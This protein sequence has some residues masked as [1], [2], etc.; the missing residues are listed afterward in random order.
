MMKSSHDDGINFSEH[1]DWYMC[2][3]MQSLAHY[4]WCMIPSASK[5]IFVCDQYVTILNSLAGDFF[6]FKFKFAKRNVKV[7]FLAKCHNFFAKQFFKKQIFKIW[8]NF[9]Q[10]PC[11]LELFCWWDDLLRRWSVDETISWWDDLLL[12]WGAKRSDGFTRGIQ[13]NKMNLSSLGK[14]ILDEWSDTIGDLSLSILNAN[15]KANFCF[16]SINSSISITCISQLI[17]T[18]KSFLLWYRLN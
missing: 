6:S 1:Q 10:I 18:N 12:R 3:K 5:V 7:D 4:S 8:L 11:P 2:S 17:F 15:V 14:L 9:F 16:V 13:I